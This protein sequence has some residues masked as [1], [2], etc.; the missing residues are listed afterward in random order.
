MFPLNL[1]MTE[2][3]LLSSHRGILG[4]KG[5]SVVFLFFNLER[6]NKIINTCDNIFYLVNQNNLPKN[7]AK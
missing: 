4:K 6:W 2:K 3:F 5:N 7:D 1:R